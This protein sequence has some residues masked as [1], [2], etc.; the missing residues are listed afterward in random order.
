MRR[1]SKREEGREKKEGKNKTKKEEMGGKRK[2]K[3]KEKKGEEKRGR[4]FKM[5]FSALTAVGSI[6]Y[7]PCVFLMMCLL[8]AWTNCWHI[9]SCS[10]DQQI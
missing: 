4:P 1:E 5:A 8:P 6:H 7:I 2:K 10:G 3:K 9:K